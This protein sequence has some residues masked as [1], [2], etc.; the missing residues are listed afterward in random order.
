[1]SSTT[2]DG[3]AARI[4]IMGVSGAGKTTV[5]IALAERLGLRFEDADDLH[6]AANVAKMSA[7]LPLTDADRVPWLRVVGEHLAA[8]PG[9]AVIACSALRHDYRDI[10]RESAP[11]AVFVMLTVD[12]ATLAQR[13]G[14]RVGHFMPVS[15]LQSQLDTLEPLG[16]DERGVTVPAVGGI[17]ATADTIVTLLA[18]QPLRS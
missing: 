3:T 12:E 13:V 15:L 4:V 2:P 11:D 1:M 16:G 9:G 5:G 14:S 10:I 8:S 18:E 17:A 6:P 7:G